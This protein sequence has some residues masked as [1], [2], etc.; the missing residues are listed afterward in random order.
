[1]TL[2]MDQPL[3]HDKLDAHDQNQVAYDLAFKSNRLVL[4]RRQS[5]ETRGELETEGD[6]SRNHLEDENISYDLYSFGD[7][8]ILLQRQQDALMEVNSNKQTYLTAVLDYSKEIGQNQHL[9]LLKYPN[10][11]TKYWLQSYVSGHGKILE[12]QIHVATNQLVGTRCL[13]MRNIMANWTPSRE[14]EFIRTLL[15]DL[16]T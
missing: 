9:D 5:L 8:T 6:S 16:Y 3:L 14:S 7:H 13:H 10:T 1:K 4:A 15:S 2:F 11:R 12:G